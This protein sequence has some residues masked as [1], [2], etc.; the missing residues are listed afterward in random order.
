MAKIDGKKF[1]YCVSIQSVPINMKIEANGLDCQKLAEEWDVLSV[2]N[3]C[4]DVKLSSWKKG[5]IRLSGKVC[6]A[7]VQ[8]CVITLD[9]L[10]L[11]IEESL[12]C[13]FVPSSSKF[14]YPN[15]DTSGKKS[16]VEV[17]ELDILPFSKDGIIDIGAVVADFIAVAIDPYPKKEGI[18]FSDIYDNN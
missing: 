17:R 16:V 8:A 12:G 7:I 9:P 5:G 6:A 11:Q 2:D 4:A 10:L 1:S 3:L 14:L 13:I 18:L 15:G